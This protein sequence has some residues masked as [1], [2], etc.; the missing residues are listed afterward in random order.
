MEPYAAVP[1]RVLPAEPGAGQVARVPGPEAAQVLQR[2]NVRVR[3]EPAD[4]SRPAADAEGDGSDAL[5]GAG[6]PQHVL[7][8]R[9]PPHPQQ[10]QPGAGDAVAP[11][12]ERAA[13]GGQGGALL[14]R[15]VQ[16][17]AIHR[18]GG[19]HGSAGH[20]DAGG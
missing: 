5:R 16:A 8:G 12:G 2:G 1:D 20:Q 7:P 17:V 14:R 15:R 9:V 4:V 3:A 19:E 10:L 11:P 6:L 13:G 18:R